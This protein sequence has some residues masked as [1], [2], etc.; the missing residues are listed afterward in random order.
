V[1]AELRPEGAARSVSPATVFLIFLRLGLTS[2]GGPVA[3]LGYFRR[4]FVDRLNW[5]DDAAYARLVAVCQLLPGP[6]SSQAG[7]AI[8]L[9]AAGLP[10]GLAAFAG[11]TLPSAG[12]M[13]AAA[14]GLSA[15]EGPAFEAVLHGL[16]LA[17]VSVVA[18]AVLLMSR[19][20]CRSLRHAT[21][22]L[23][24]L[25]LIL[26]APHP[27]AA[28]AIILATGLAGWLTAGRPGGVRPPSHPARRWAPSAALTFLALLVALPILRVVAPEPWVVLADSFYR[29]GAL[30]FGGGHVVL[31]LLQAETAEWITP[32]AFLAGYGAA[33]ALPGPLFA[34]A[35][36]LGAI[37]DASGANTTYGLLA[38]G[39][40]FLP[41][42]LMIAAARPLW[43]E[44]VS[45]RFARAI[46][47]VNA[48]VVGV[49]AAA[50]VNPV[51][52]SALRTPGD[53][54][55]ALVALAMLL[56]PRVP[57]FAAVAIA[58]AAGAAAY[59]LA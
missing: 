34:F 52:A 11:F 51:A 45:P 16:K 59:A 12:L 32:D 18:H 40:V 29:A 19:A 15:F 57:A 53:A 55:I 33:Q 50:L 31:P 14:Y 17:A 54:V 2:F 3:H 22:A 1:T 58:T 48:A 27:L 8:G 46:S 6:A 41:G 26:A 10:G 37:S 23:L 24:A 21:L 7:F 47:L 13:I 9:R 39:A 42:L 25:I 28:P 44:T 49:L 56:V 20:H 35:A 4:T 30:V 43:E 36:Y 5:L 38:L